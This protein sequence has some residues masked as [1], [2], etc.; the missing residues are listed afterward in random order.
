MMLCS[1]ILMSS[2][3]WSSFSSLPISMSRCRLTMQ[4][5]ITLPL[6]VPLSSTVLSKISCFSSSIVLV[7]VAFSSS[8]L[9]SHT[10]TFNLSALL[11]PDGVLFFLLSGP[12]V[13]AESS[14]GL[15]VQYGGITYRWPLHGDSNDNNN[16]D[17]ED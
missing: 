15:H 9:T 7:V 4:L 6:L 17:D 3:S 8:M 11:G 2:S 13:Q 5:G 16:D 1:S 10:L 14:L 12:E